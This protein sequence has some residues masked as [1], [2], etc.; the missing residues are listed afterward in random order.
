MTGHSGPDELARIAKDVMRVQRMALNVRTAVRA[1]RTPFSPERVGLRDS[2]EEGKEK[3]FRMADGE[4]SVVSDLGDVFVTADTLLTDAFSEL[5]TN[6]MEFSGDR[7]EIS[8]RAEKKKDRVRVL[9][10]DRSGPVDLKAV[11]SSAGRLDRLLEKGEYSGAGTGLFMV[12]AVIERYG[13]DVS[14]SHRIEGDPSSGLKVE[15]DLPSGG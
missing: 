14:F 13:G 7:A 10:E 12:R 8:V 2:F 1:V 5:V 15:I 4:A 6:S 9:F 3:A 11:G